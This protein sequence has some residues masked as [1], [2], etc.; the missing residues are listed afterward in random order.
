MSPGQGILTGAQPYI[1]STKTGY[2]TCLSK[3]KTVNA[4][5]A[6]TLSPTLSEGSY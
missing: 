2:T 5:A 4:S 1:V 6:A 3:S